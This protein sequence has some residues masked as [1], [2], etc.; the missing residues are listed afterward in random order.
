VAFAFGHP[1][2]GYF[3]G[4]V[5]VDADLHVCVRVSLVVRVDILIH[6]YSP[7]SAF[8]TYP[9]DLNATCIH[10]GDF[11]FAV[12]II[13]TLIELIV[14]ILPLPVLLVLPL[15]PKQRIP[16]TCLLCVGLLVPIIGALR[17]YYVYID[18][19]VSWDVYW[20]AEPEWICSEVENYLALVRLVTTQ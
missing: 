5:L 20:N 15:D 19:V 9:P 13:N 10:T 3:H 16:V 12:S 14:V 18:I 8:W 17:C 7:V 4:R 11:L 6:L 2:A 1:S